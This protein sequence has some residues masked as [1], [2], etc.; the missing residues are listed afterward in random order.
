MR[1]ARFFLACCVLSVLTLGPANCAPKTVV[2]PQGQAAYTADQVAQVIA[3][4]QNSAIQANK[5]AILPDVQAIQ[6][7]S[8]CVDIEKT[9][10]KVPTGWQATVR[11][12]WTALKGKLSPNAS[13]TLQTAITAVDVALASIG[14]D[15]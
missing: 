9:L 3:A 2:T 10:Q 14:G 11:A 6:I 7:V 4:L 1:I 13:Q 5:Q 12:A 8:A 15:L